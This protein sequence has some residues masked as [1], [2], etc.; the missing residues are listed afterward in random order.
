MNKTTTATT[1]FNFS[2]LVVSQRNNLNMKP[3]KSGLNLSQ[4][5]LEIRKTDGIITTIIII[6]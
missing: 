6:N 3:W 2:S 5:L 1:R 4:I